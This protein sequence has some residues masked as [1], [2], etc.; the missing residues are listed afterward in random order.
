MRTHKG[1]FRPPDLPRAAPEGRRD[2]RPGEGGLCQDL[3][4]RLEHTSPK[5]HHQPQLVLER[6]VGVEEGFPMGPRRPAAGQVLHVL[7]PAT[8]VEGFLWGHWGR[9]CRGLRVWPSPGQVKLLATSW[10]PVLEQKEGDRS[11]CW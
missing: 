5:G 8:D 1:L 3:T 4:A 11:G 9:G 6:V 7:G 10:A 2:H